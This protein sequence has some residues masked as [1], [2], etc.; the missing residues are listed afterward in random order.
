MQDSRIRLARLSA[1][2][3]QHP[4]LAKATTFLGDFGLVETA[5]HEQTI[6]YRGFGIDP[7]VYIAEKS[8]DAK[9]HFVGATWVV[10]S[11]EELDRAVALHPSSSVRESNRPGGGRIV[12]L[13]DPNGFEVNLIHGQEEMEPRCQGADVHSHT[14]EPEGPANT[15]LEKPRKGEVR[16]MQ[17]QASPVHKLGHYG[18]LVPAD[19]YKETMDWYRSHLALT[20]TDIVYDPDDDQD[21]I[22]FLH[23]DR[24]LQFVDHHVK[25][26]FPLSLLP[27]R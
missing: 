23:I 14:T 16:R 12:T 21:V 15:A 9:R 25:F 24:G 2:H 6:F 27:L 20:P 19:R 18:F 1:V 10:E 4:D 17:P 11:S 5:R 26:T 8:P 3:Y 22:A 7:C 13:K